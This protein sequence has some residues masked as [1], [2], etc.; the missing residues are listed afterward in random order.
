MEL[1]AARKEEKLNVYGIICKKKQLEQKGK[2]TYARHYSLKNL[3]SRTGR[4][5]DNNMRVSTAMW[6]IPAYPVK[7]PSP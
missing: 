2:G 6:F 3:T 1:S 7:E 5:E 4:P